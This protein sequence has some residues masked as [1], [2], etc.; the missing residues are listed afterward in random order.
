MPRYSGILISEVEIKD[1][2]KWLQNNLQSIGLKPINNIVD[3]TNY[4]LH[5]F[6]QPMHAFDLI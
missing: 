1:S 3:I 5:S 2:P 6:G 4:I